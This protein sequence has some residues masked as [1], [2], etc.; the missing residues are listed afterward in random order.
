MK[1]MSE[2]FEITHR[3][4][5]LSWKHHY[6]VASIKKI[7]EITKGK[8]KGKLQLSKETDYEKISE[9]LERAAKITEH[10]EH[11]LRNLKSIAET[12]ELSHRCD[13]A[14]SDRAGGVGG[15]RFTL[16]NVISIVSEMSR[17]SSRLLGSIT[18]PQPDTLSR[19]FLSQRSVP[20]NIRNHVAALGRPRE[21]GAGGGGRE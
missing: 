4:V 13:K 7:E 16:R 11:Y 21:P 2:L 8:D 18:P 12:I 1:R 15:M 9:F 14:P 20:T 17:A 10:E 6:E 19:A 5:N 3:C